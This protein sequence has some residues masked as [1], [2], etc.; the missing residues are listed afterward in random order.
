MPQT[1][2]AASQQPPV[3]E[4]DPVDANRGVIITGIVLVALT[5]VIV[6]YLLVTGIL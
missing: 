2:S 5:A 6:I 3:P 4:V 1:N